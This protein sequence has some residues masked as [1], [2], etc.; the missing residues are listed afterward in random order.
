MLTVFPIQCFIQV[1]LPLFIMNTT[2]FPPQAILETERLLLKE[3]NIDILQYLFNKLPDEEIISYLGLPSAQA[4]ETERTFIPKGYASYKIAFQNFLIINK[5][6]NSVIGRAGFHTWHTKHA[7]AEIGYAISSDDNK[8]KGYMGEAL[9]AIIAYGFN[10]MDLNRIEAY[11]GLNNIPSHKLV[12]ALGFIQEGV[13]REHYCN[14]GRIEDS[15]C[16]S[17]LKREYK[18]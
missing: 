2:I 6:T 18:P 4:L 10:E 12:K 9:K 13:A 3:L 1:Y 11:I 14:N 17:L 5:E 8:R 16:Y 7:R 15:A